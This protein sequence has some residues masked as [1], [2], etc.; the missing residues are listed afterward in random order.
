MKITYMLLAVLVALANLTL[1]TGGGIF[2]SSSNAY[3]HPRPET[4]TTAAQTDFPQDT[5]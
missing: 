4:T 5:L 2:S 3:A 1:A